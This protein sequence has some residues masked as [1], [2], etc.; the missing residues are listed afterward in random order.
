MPSATIVQKLDQ[1]Q[2][3]R[4]ICANHL[5]FTKVYWSAQWSNYESFTYLQKV[6]V[7]Y[8]AVIMDC[9]VDQV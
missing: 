9:V 3:V 2:L 4:D 6:N 5:N 8:I 1:P 7:C